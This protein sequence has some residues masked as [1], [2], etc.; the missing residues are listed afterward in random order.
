MLNNQRAFPKDVSDLPKHSTDFH[1][2][3][4]KAFP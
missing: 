3:A 2:D 4:F 1:L